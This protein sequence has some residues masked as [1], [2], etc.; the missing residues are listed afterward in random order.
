MAWWLAGR[1]LDRAHGRLLPSI[2]SDSSNSRPYPFILLSGERHCESRVSCVAQG[3]QHNEPG[4]RWNPAPSTR[5]SGA[6]II[7]EPCLSYHDKKQRGLSFSTTV[8]QNHWSARKTYTLLLRLWN[9][10]HSETALFMC[11]PKLMHSNYDNVFREWF[12]S[13]IMRR[14]EYLFQ[15]SYMATWRARLRPK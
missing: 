6:L 4:L 10:F 11:P 13:Q 9:G 12:N 5:S 1:T 7:K 8:I 14:G 2:L 3:T 15:L